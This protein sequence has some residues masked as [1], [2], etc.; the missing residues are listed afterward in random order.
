MQ[1][2]KHPLSFPKSVSRHLFMK[3]AA[4][5]VSREVCNFAEVWKVPYSSILFNE[6]KTRKQIR[7]E[8]FLHDVRSFRRQEN[9][10]N[11]AQVLLRS[12]LAR[13]QE[14]SSQEFCYTE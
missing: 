5:L 6:S 13:F 7:R 4:V 10:E 2:E 3:R 8:V 9:D 11:K 12:H 14:K 1:L